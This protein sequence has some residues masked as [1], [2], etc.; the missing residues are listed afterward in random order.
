MFIHGPQ[1]VGYPRSRES[2]SFLSGKGCEDEGRQPSVKSVTYAL[3]YSYRP[4]VLRA[5]TWEG[6]ASQTKTLHLQK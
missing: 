4:F 5:P 3:R 1:T 6:L 2:C